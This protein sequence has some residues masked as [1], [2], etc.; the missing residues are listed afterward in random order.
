MGPLEQFPD[1]LGR[2]TNVALVVTP[3]SFDILDS[4]TTGLRSYFPSSSHHSEET[5]MAESQLLPS[6]L[7]FGVYQMRP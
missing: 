2:D 6:R 7:M 4:P 5:K 3:V 1:K